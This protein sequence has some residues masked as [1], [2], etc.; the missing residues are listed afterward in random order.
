MNFISSS[1]LS[2]TAD[3]QSWTPIFG[4]G[5]PVFEGGY[6]L[7]YGGTPT[8]KQRGRWDSCF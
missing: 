1:D 8:F 2:L 7:L 6:I 5:S 3:L 4:A